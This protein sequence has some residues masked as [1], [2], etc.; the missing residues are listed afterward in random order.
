MS[1]N[2]DSI[3]F[4]NV[5]QIEKSEKGLTLLRYPRSVEESLAVPEFDKDGKFT[6]IYTGHRVGAQFCIGIEVRFYSE[7]N[8]IEFTAFGEADFSAMV[9][10][11]DYQAGV[12]QSPA[13]KNT[14]R[15][16]RPVNMMGVGEKS[17]NRFSVNTWRI[18]FLS[19][20]P[21]TL[22]D[23]EVEGGYSYPSEK[24]KKTMLV[25]G[26]SISR[27]CGSPFITVN[28]T[29]IAA[30]ILGYDVKNKA[31]AG[32]CFCEKE[33]LKF[34]SDVQFDIGYFELGTNIADRPFDVIDERV[35]GF[36]DEMA[37]RF[38][39]K[40]LYFMTPV[41]GLSDVSSTADRYEEN[42]ARSRRVIESHAKRYNNATILDG[43]E[44]LDKDYY[45]TADI[46]HPS[47]F[48]HIMMGVNLAR[49]IMGSEQGN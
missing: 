5:A 21:I 15:C 33:V 17:T 13:G 30:E 27:G 20:K 46:L 41:K 3:Q 9:F 45:L 2:S 23:L 25:Y 42:F 40:R 37:K 1:I 29:G 43:H 39:K 48:G 24:P 34:L 16:N 6:K 49:M 11:G 44:L 7:G 14:F 32:G 12:F 28:Y 18:A 22:C 10:I 47:A 26:S 36:I 19:D 35:G 4:F 38:P 31:I 8:E